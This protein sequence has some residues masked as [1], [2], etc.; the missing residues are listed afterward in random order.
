[1]TNPSWN[2]DGQQPGY[3]AG[4]SSPYGDSGQGGG[5]GSNPTAPYGSGAQDSQPTEAYGQYQGTGSPYGAPM[6]GTGQAQGAPSYPSSDYGQT[7]QYGQGAGYGQTS[8][9]PQASQYPQVGQADSGQGYSAYGQSG[10]SSTATSYG[11]SAYGGGS[12]SGSTPPKKGFPIWGWALIA[13]AAVAIIGLVLGIVLPGAFGNHQAN[14]PTPSVTTVTTSTTAPT[15]SSTPTPTASAGP[16]QP[17]A[18]GRTIPLSEKTTPTVATMAFAGAGH[19]YGDEKT[20]S[21]NGGTVSRYSSDDGKCTAAVWTFQNAP[22][23]DASDATPT[24]NR[25]TLDTKEAATGTVEPTT[26][27]FVTNQGDTLEM[28]Q[29]QMEYKD[30]KDVEYVMSRTF[31]GSG[32]E[33]IF[34]LT[35]TKGNLSHGAINAAK[36]WLSIDLKL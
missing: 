2:P 28:T 9:Y 3:G 5:Y 1:M 18:T 15:Q 12:G 31:A 11:S 21:V 35:C 10:S 17:A 13:V 16:T 25:Y 34:A 22:Y 36:Q 29:Y 14:T 24:A 30:G 8:Q 19:G 7:T 33:L 4:G 27:T 26:T 32:T 23:S 20:E 6:Y